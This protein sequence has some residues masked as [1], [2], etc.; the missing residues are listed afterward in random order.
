[1][2]LIN[3]MKE[4]QEGLEASI[5][6]SPEEIKAAALNTI[7]EA[8]DTVKGSGSVMTELGSLK[9]AYIDLP[10]G[11]ASNALT[12]TGQLLSAHPVDATVTT[13]GALTD[14]AK[15]VG[16]IAVA[17]LPLGIAAAGSSLE[18]AKTVVKAP[19]TVPLA[20][21]KVVY[22]GCNKMLDL[23][24][25]DDIPAVQPANDNSSEAP[26]EPSAPPMAA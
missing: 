16:K 13:F 12:A 23:L 26:S 10:L 3:A 20:A 22:N 19:V 8:I 24:G 4:A 15:N 5:V 11:A 1:M 14:A 9:D 2:G 17:P 25:G 6:R 18:A 7:H 21:G